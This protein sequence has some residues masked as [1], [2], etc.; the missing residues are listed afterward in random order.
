M[1]CAPII[2][3]HLGNQSILNM[4]NLREL[5]LCEATATISPKLFWLEDA[6]QPPDEILCLSKKR[7]CYFRNEH[8]VPSKAHW[9]ITVT[10][11]ACLNGTN[12]SSNRFHN[13]ILDR[14]WFSAYLCLVIGARSPGRP[15]TPIHFDLFLIR[16]PRGS[17]A[18]YARFS[19][20][21]RTVFYSFKNL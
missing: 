6:L 7:N 15:M 4:P 13:K 9:V 18:N 8:D 21:L 16:Y 10:K 14:D 19:G 12:F 11:A 20:F 17:H 2:S 3:Y 1:L 5:F